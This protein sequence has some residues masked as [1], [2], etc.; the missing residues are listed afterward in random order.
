MNEL[1]LRTFV[2]FTPHLLLY[3]TEMSP[4]PGSVM[5]TLPGET[6]ELHCEYGSLSSPAVQWF[7]EGQ[8]LERHPTLNASRRVYRM[9][10]LRVSIVTLSGVEV[11][12]GGTYECRV[13]GQIKQT[14]VIVRGKFLENKTERWSERLR[15][16]SV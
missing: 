7:F 6:R 3:R 13:N 16:S 5:V 9:D 8:P 2:L 14:H 12:H 10:R 11:G 1:S 4:P 15:P